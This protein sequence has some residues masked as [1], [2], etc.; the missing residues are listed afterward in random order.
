MTFVYNFTH[1]KSS[2]HKNRGKYYIWSLPQKT[3]S[4]V[5]VHLVVSGS[6]LRIDVHAQ[7]C[8]FSSRSLEVR[9]QV[10]HKA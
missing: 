2:C 1:P 9:P 5:G 10:G 8:I 6:K 7:A 3:K 4:I